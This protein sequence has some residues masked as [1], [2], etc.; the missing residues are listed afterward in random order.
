MK[1]K[2]TLIALLSITSIL[3]G[4]GGSGNDK[5]SSKV[6]DFSEMS[7]S[8][9]EQIYD[10]DDVIGNADLPGNGTPIKPY[11]IKTKDDLLEFMNN[12]VTLPNVHYQLEN[13]IEFK[14]EW[15][16]VC[17]GEE[18]FK[19]VFNGAG[20]TIKGLEITR[21][22]K[23]QI[24]YGFIGQ[25]EKGKIANL[26][27]EMTI[28]MQVLGKSTS[29]GIGGAVAYASNSSV[30]NV[31]VNY[32]KFEVVT[33]QNEKSYLY[34]GGI[35]SYFDSTQDDDGMY[36]TDIRNCSV[37]GD[38]IV[39]LEDATD[40]VD[41]EGGI[42]AVMD[43][44]YYTG[45]M[46]VNN[47]SFVGDIEGGLY[48]GGIGAS[49]SY[50]TSI[51]NCYV[52]SDT[53]ASFEEDTAYV[54][55]IAGFTKN[56]SALIGNYAKVNHIDGTIA[57]SSIYKS[58]S[59]D[60]AGFI[61]SDLYESD[62]DIAGCAMYEN[63]ATYGTI[64]GD[65]K[66]TADNKVE[67][68]EELL[69]RIGFST[70]S[71][72]FKDGKPVLNKE[73]PEYK[74]KLKVNPNF[75]GE[76]G[77]EYT[78]DAGNYSSIS[79]QINFYYQAPKRKGF[80]F[81]GL[82]YDDNATIMWRWYAPIN[83]D[84]SIYCG[85][86]D[87]DP[88]VGDYTVI[89]QYYESKIQSGTWKFTEDSFYWLRK[90]GSYSEYKYRFNG[91]YV[92][93]GEY[94]GNYRAA[95]GGYEDE[96]FTLQDDGTLTG[97]DVN[98]DSAEYLATPNNGNVEVPSIKGEPFLGKWTNGKAVVTIDEYCTAVAYFVD[99]KVDYFGGVQYDGFTIILDASPIIARIELRYDATTDTLVG[100]GVTYERV[101]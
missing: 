84:L 46:A 83:S 41:A 10:D 16:P 38:I 17:A 91:K 11:L 5:D 25:M 75:G 27:L 101:K 77:N 78:I 65:V 49:M 28:D 44:G 18:S 98:S 88:L 86:A 85:Y 59:G 24:F 79:A 47:C 37:T 76:K 74:V 82:Y 50:Y 3:A 31:H 9:S 70:N 94:Q 12:T 92:F 20:H 81:H 35:A 63:Y 67:V 62:L 97:Y 72:N 33:V 36:Y 58:Y 34:A 13:D 100:D 43:T 8:K 71:W 54:G 19:G 89:C 23:T 32:N 73:N 51:V 53:L 30:Q 15:T 6:N 2:S 80:S 26:N 90:D 87:L 57:K 95:L 93:L 21:S 56:E 1:K 40:V 64:K 96:I 14:G 69:K 29:Y 7:N 66:N 60:I 39:N 52:E 45:L 55:G 61:A 42:V 99:K 68:S 22:S 48:V 4:C